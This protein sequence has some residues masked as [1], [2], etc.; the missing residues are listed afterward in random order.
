M[1]NTIQVIK[2]IMKE[3]NISQA[4]L[5]ELIGLGRGRVNSI[6]NNRV[7]LTQDYIERIA[8]ALDVPVST[9]IGEDDT[10]DVGEID[11]EEC[12]TVVDDEELEDEEPPVVVNK[13]SKSSK[14]NKLDKLILETEEQ[15]AELDTGRNILLDKLELLRERKEIEERA[16]ELDSRIGELF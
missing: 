5:G 16:K 13:K 8:E 11:V 9:L 6:M 3:R 12:E 10:V 2:D 7:N 14:K 1:T 4:E 15:I